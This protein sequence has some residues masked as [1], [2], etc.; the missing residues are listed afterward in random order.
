MHSR[1]ATYLKYKVSI[2]DFRELDD[3]LTRKEGHIVISQVPDR[4]CLQTVVVRKPG[5]INQGT[6]SMRQMTT[7]I[8]N[9]MQ[10]VTILPKGRE[11][12]DA[13]FYIDDLQV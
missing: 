5:S 4:Q 12:V 7:C 3:F 10:S 13:S 11:H 9:W 1:R 8:R 2:R 6:G